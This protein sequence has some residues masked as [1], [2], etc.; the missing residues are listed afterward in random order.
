MKG[1]GY[2][3]G[4]IGTGN[5]AWHLALAFE[6]AGH[7]IVHVYNRDMDKA[8]DFVRDLYNA[9]AGNSEDLRSTDAEI[10]IMPV[11]DGAIES[12]SQEIQLPEDCILAHT[13]GAIGLSKLGYAHTENTGVFYPL[14]TFSKGKTVD[15]KKTP[16]CIEA[17]NG[18][19]ESV[20]WELAESISATVHLIDSVKRKAIHLAAVFACNF[21]NHMFTISQELMNEL[22]L[23]FSLL[24]PLISETLN[25]SLEIGPQNGQTG[26]ARRNDL[27]TLDEQYEA[28]K[29]DAQVAELYRMISQHILDYYSLED[30]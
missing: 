10:F 11:S 21:S 14:Q 24:K 26:P 23:D 4:L 1:K 16:L 20:L 30:K 22:G 12:L 3:I 19:T 25:K 5:V 2:K 7:S 13:S 27:S 29:G 8:K 6:N 17:S 28:L 15:F 9:T 18:H